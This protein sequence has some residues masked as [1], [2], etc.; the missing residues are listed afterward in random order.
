M[1]NQEQSCNKRN[2]NRTGELVLGCTVIVALLLIETQFFLTP[3]AAGSNS[4]SSNSVIQ[5]DWPQSGYNASFLSSVQWGNYDKVTLSY[6]KSNVGVMAV[7][8]NGLLFG[9]HKTNRYSTSGLI[10]INLKTGEIKWDHSGMRFLRGFAS[11]NGL[12]FVS[13]SEYDARGTSALYAINETSGRTVWIN[14]QVAL[15]CA[16]SPLSYS[17]GTA[18]VNVDN[19]GDYSLV[20]LNS[21]NGKI[22][23]QNLI[24]D[25]VELSYAPSFR[26]NILYDDSN[27]EGCCGDAIWAS[28]WPHSSGHYSSSFYGIT[29][30]SPV[31]GVHDIFVGAD[32]GYVYSISRET[33]AVVW[34]SS[35][36]GTCGTYSCPATAEALYGNVLVVTN[37][38]G[39]SPTNPLICGLDAGTGAKLWCQGSPQP[40]GYFGADVIVGSQVLFVNSTNALIALKLDSGGIAWTY[41]LGGTAS[42]VNIFP[43]GNYLVVSEGYALNG[44]TFVSELYVLNGIK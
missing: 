15:C 22:I 20:A 2:N 23:W 39:Y 4:A 19:G 25:P 8:I 32:S 34:N 44:N 35:I 18:Y 36:L 26:G 21:S 37:V 42:N 6:S 12:L 5:H 9:Y 3:V 11:N 33:G 13:S 28:Y 29:T 14:D 41:Q 17:N 10:V 30:S 1:K 7:G 24:G 38:N 43:D 31:V 40:N 16:A 27:T